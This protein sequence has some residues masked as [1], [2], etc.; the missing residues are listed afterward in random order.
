MSTGLKVSG[1][2]LRPWCAGAFFS[3]DFVS[4][5]TTPV[6]TK[7]TAHPGDPENRL[8][9]SALFRY[10]LPIDQR[11]KLRHLIV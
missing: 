6:R 2:G 4:T 11:F 10:Q 7:S 8:S 1:F 5:H 3:R 9:F